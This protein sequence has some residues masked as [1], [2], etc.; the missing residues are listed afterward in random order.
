MTCL[1]GFDLPFLRSEID[2]L[3]EDFGNSIDTSLA[4]FGWRS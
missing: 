2:K 4:N 3:A 1:L